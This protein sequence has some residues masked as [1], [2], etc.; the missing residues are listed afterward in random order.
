MGADALCRVE[1]LG[2][3]YGQRHAIEL[4]CRAGLV[5]GMKS[6]RG[7][8]APKIGE[9]HTL[10]IPTLAT[11]SDTALTRDVA[12]TMGDMACP[13]HSCPAATWCF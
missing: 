10:A 4:T 6:L 2:F 1:T 9:S 3:D 13:T 12:I 5:E 7:E 8:W 11:I